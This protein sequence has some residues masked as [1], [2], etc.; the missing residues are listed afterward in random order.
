MTLL[1]LS[2]FAQADNTLDKLKAENYLSRKIKEIE[3]HYRTPVGSSE[4]LYFIKTFFLL[5]SNNLLQISTTRKNSIQ[6]R[7]GNCSYHEYEN[8]VFFNPKD[9]MDIRFEGKNTED[10]VGVLKIIF[11]AQVCKETLAVYGYKTKLSSGYCDDWLQ[12]GRDEFSKKEILIPFLVSDDTNFSKIKKA[13]EYL[14]D[15]CK[16][17]DDP[18]GN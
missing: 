5:S 9:I 10:P 12:S 1:H 17:E 7:S 8:T 3:G 16:A 15:L 13:F 18:F 14:R 6:A 4:R 11:N 2:L